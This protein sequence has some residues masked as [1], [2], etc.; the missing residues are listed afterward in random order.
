M[1]RKRFDAHD[2]DMFKTDLMN[3][4]FDDELDAVKKAYRFVEFVMRPLSTDLRQKL[5]E[6]EFEDRQKIHKYREQN[7]KEDDADD[8]AF[9]ESH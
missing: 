4:D 1:F 6:K 7:N 9:S 5:E 8:M 2:K 3:F